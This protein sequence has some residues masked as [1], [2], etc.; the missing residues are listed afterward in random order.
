MGFFC[1]LGLEDL[2]AIDTKRLQ[3][4]LGEALQ[5]LELELSAH[6][7]RILELE[8]KF[9]EELIIRLQQRKAELAAGAEVAERGRVELS[10]RLGEHADRIEAVDQLRQTIETRVKQAE[11]KASEG[12][13]ETKA[14][15]EVADSQLVALGRFQR[16]LEDVNATAK[17]VLENDVDQFRQHQEQ[18]ADKLEG[19]LRGLQEEF[20]SRTVAEAMRQPAA[21]VAIRRGAL[22]PPPFNGSFVCGHEEPM[23]WEAATADAHDHGQ[24][25]VCDLSLGGG[26]KENC[27]ALGDSQRLLCT[28]PRMVSPAPAIRGN[29]GQVYLLPS[30]NMA[31]T[32][33]ATG[34][35]SRTDRRHSSPTASRAR[36]V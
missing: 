26:E 23:T 21:Y 14:I 19:Q 18:L 24:Q 7:S 17:R 22:Q 4:V 16:E 1:S 25:D 8:K 34:S 2:V 30:A 35:P 9:P 36:H 33:S 28:K 12:H 20:R 29:G 32:I 31:R 11:A 3:R 27:T 15:R 10:Q 5:Q 6:E 13:L